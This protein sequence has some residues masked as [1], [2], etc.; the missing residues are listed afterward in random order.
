[1]SRNISGERSVVDY[2]VSDAVNHFPMS[3]SAN[4]SPMSDAVN[5]SPRRYPPPRPSA[6]G[7]VP[8]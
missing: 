2:E 4:H 1:M 5:H 8:V 7:V 3:D 6:R